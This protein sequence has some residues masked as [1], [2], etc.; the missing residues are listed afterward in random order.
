MSL[1]DLLQNKE[2]LV[3]DR[4]VI[5]GCV[6]WGRHGAGILA[7]DGGNGG[8]GVLDPD[9]KLL[10]AFRFVGALPYGGEIR[11]EIYG[12]VVVDDTY[13]PTEMDLPNTRS[14]TYLRVERV[15]EPQKVWP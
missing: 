15:L 1:P 12:T 5:D 14:R 11:A 8:I 6:F 4:I 13:Q 3:G 9:G 7:C 10:E 2:R